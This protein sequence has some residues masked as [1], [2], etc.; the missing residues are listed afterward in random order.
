MTGQLPLWTSQFR[1]HYGGS[2]LLDPRPFGAWLRELPGSHSEHALTL[3]V[4]E[5]MVR[6]RRRCA[7]DERV[8]AAVVERWG[9]ALVDD[10]RLVERLYGV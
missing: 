6:R 8:S 3:G 10:P 7:D 9:I 4:D 5:A 2:V 1:T